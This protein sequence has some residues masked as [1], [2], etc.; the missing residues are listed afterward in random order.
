MPQ[1]FAPLFVC[2][3]KT[4]SVHF[5]PKFLMGAFILHTAEHGNSLRLFSFDCFS[6]LRL[7]LKNGALTFV[8]VVLL[9]FQIIIRK[10]LCD[11]IL[12]FSLCFLADF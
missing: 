4:L 1:I 10:T 6:L 8:L 2:T 12:T 11:K 3:T 7:I 5:N 9:N